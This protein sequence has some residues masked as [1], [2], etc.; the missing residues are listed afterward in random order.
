MT[1]AGQQSALSF[2]LRAGLELAQLWINRGQIRKARDLIAPI[3]NR[4][5]EGLATPDLI[6]ARRMLERTSAPARQARR[7]TA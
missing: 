1:L 3:Y 5:I 2:E 4:F 7:G 6:L